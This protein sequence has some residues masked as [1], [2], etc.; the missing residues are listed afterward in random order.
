MYFSGSEEIW[1]TQAKNALLSQMS[2]DLIEGMLEEYPMEVDYQA[3][4]LGYVK[5]SSDEE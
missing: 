4:G 1:Y 3:I 5:L 2:T